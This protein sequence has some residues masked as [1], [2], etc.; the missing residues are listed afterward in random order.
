MKTGDYHDEMNHT[1]FMTWI[2]NQLLPNLPE[3]SVLVLDNASYHN[4]TMEPNITSASLKADMINWL[5]QKNVQFDQT[6][7]KP[8]LYKI[9]QDNKYKFPPVYKLDRLLEEHGHKV[10]RLPPY[11]PDLNPIEKIWASVKNWVAARNTDFTMAAVERLTRQR[12]EELPVEEWINICAHVKKYED[13]QIEREHLLDSAMDHL[14]FTVNTGSSDEN[15]SDEE[16]SD[17][18]G[19]QSLSTSESD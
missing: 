11:H 8:E 5:N 15:W 3:K 16:E 7:T 19:V 13:S 1:N 18:S 17:I 12:F 2:R 6:L 9:I 14:R 10:L 4:V